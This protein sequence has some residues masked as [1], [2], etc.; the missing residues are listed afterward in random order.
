MSGGHGHDLGH[1]GGSQNKKI[2][3]LIALMAA[4]PQGLLGSPRVEI[5]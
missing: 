3:M 4:R 2:A 1:E 5:A